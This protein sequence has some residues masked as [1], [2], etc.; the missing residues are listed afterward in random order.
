MAK[1]VK[2]GGRD[3]KPG[4]SGNP[5]GRPPLPEEVRIAR[6][7]NKAEFERIVNEYIHMSLVEI[8]DRAKDPSTSAL[9]VIIA[10]IVAEAIKRGDERRL[11]FILDRLI[12]PVPKNV[13]LD[14]EEGKGFEIVIKDYTKKKTDGEN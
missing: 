1:G 12:G 13:Q 4:Q 10:K 9:E 14:S 3:F 5:N 11:G 2:T 8:Q 7:L 6:S